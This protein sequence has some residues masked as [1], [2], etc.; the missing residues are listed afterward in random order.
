MLTK[1]RQAEF[2]ARKAEDGATQP[3]EFEALVAVFDNVDNQ[4][5]RIK[6]GAFDKTLEAWRK[7]G[8][9]I[10]IVLAHEWSDPWAHIGYAMPEHVKAIPGRGLYVSKAVLDIE[11][12]PVARQVHRLM[13]R[14]T[15]KEF[16]FG[17]R[18][19]DNGERKAED[20][21]YDLTGLDLIEFGPCL[22]GVNDS[23][24]LLAVKAL[25]E[26]E[27]RRESGEEPTLEERMNRIEAMLL[28]QGKAIATFTT[29][30]SASTTNMPVEIKGYAE[31]PNESVVREACAEHF[32]GMVEGRVLVLEV[33]ASDVLYSVEIPGGATSKYRVSYEIDSEDV[34]AFGDPALVAGTASDPEHEDTDGEIDTKTDPEVITE[35]AED[36]HET[37]ADDPEEKSSGEQSARQKSA[38]IDLMLRTQ[39]LDNLEAEM[40][41]VTETEEEE[42]E[43]K[44]L[45]E[46]LAEVEAEFADP[47][48]FDVGKVRLKQ[49]ED[50]LEALE[51]G[52]LRDV[53]AKDQTVDDV[54][55]SLEGTE[56]EL[57]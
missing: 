22:K 31:V 19:Q 41:F 18:V 30:T 9:P 47:M 11:D 53:I 57:S 7:S 21:A 12:N 13:E 14:R 23:T 25:V 35:D 5:D 8:D 56:K 10:P 37:S 29:N 17:Y 24:E 44:S 55:R 27:Q 4:G 51:G 49:F 20:G 46:Q 45:D 36:V 16:S 6:S 43:T 54:E 34:V 38:E 32:G 26:E 42:V 2:K 48:P 33:T 3:G 39:A 28:E 50:G 40:G 15:L 52:V 1:Q